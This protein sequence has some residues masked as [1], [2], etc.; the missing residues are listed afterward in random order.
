MFRKSRLKQYKN[1]S[2]IIIPY[3]KQLLSFQPDRH[4]VNSFKNSKHN[5]LT[6]MNYEHVLRY[7][8]IKN[9][10]NKDIYEVVIKLIE[11]VTYPTEWKN[12]NLLTQKVF[13]KN[14]L[15]SCSLKKMA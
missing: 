14:I 5:E 3:L 7:E 15:K 2:L 10:E 6:V 13:R 11:E 12:E 9:N 1:D 4:W 8:N